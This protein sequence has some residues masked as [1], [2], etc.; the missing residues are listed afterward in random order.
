MA[1]DR[2]RPRESPPGRRS[3]LPPLPESLL[4]PLLD[5]AADVL[6]TLEPQA[7][8]GQPAPAGRLRPRASPGCGPPAAAE[9]DPDR[10]AFHEEAIERFV[11]QPEVEAALDAW[12]PADMVAG[13]RRRRQ[14]CR[15]AVARVGALRRPAAGMGVRARRDHRG[16][17]APARG[18]GGER[19]AAAPATCRSP[20]SRSRGAGPT[21]AAS[22][23]SRRRA[24]LERELREE[25]K[26][27]RAR[28]EQVGQGGRRR[29]ARSAEDA[30][31]AARQGEGRRRG[32]RSAAAA[33]RPSAPGPPSRSAVTCGGSSPRPSASSRPSPRRR[34]CAPADL[35]ALVD[36]GELARRLAEGLGGVGRQGAPARCPSSGAATAPE[37][38]DR[39][40]AA[41][42][43]RGEAGSGHAP[44]AGADPAGD[45]GRRPEGLDAMLRTR[46]T[47]CSWSTA[48]TSRCWLGRRTAVRAARPAASPRSR[49]LQLRTRCGVDRRV[50]RR[51]REGLRPPRRPGSR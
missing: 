45:G 20:R 21:P 13:G 3:A 17:R 16:V 22:T 46:A 27:R 29:R 33:R 19:R 32:G 51:R 39:S 10:R 31:R 11:E 50:R 12:D 47:P 41:R 37:G 23:P 36:A 24:R 7:R 14:A 43:R 34:C 15:P 9:G 49:R 4:S 18:A 8:A 35:Q 2:R 6:P 42:E 30:R 26:G 44:A 25:R 1:R 5:T 28:E 40:E 38:G 48:T